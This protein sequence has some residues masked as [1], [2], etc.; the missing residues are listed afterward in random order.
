[1]AEELIK[2]N[3][4]DNVRSVLESCR[5]N[6]NILGVNA[7]SYHL[8]PPLHSQLSSKTIVAHFGFSKKI[9]SK[10]LDP[11]FFENDPVAN[12]VMK[13][14]RS[15]T[16]KKAITSQQLSENQQKFV[17]IFT[18]LGLKGG[19]SVPLYGRNG[20]DSY[21][22]FKFEYKED[23]LDEEKVQQVIMQAQFSHRKI[24]LLVERDFEKI[25]KL[26]S[27]EHEV[28]CW[29]AKSK[30]NSEIASLLKLSTSTVDTFVRRLF[31]KLEVT[32]R[33]S[34]VLEGVSRGYIKI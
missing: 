1:M 23:F 31:A 25:I 4:T 29:I 32:D 28:L 26:S 34:A 24:C 30:S 6:L 15:M 2:L 19:I 21:S 16:W 13:V 12:Y 8:T 9:V 17:E 5:S 33:I 18:G 3:P 22:A 10:Y 27:R 11:T 20:R 7:G 14:G